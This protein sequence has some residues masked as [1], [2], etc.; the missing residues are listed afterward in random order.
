MK[1]EALHSYWLDFQGTGSCYALCQKRKAIITLN[2]V[3]TLRDTEITG[4]VRMSHCCNRGINMGMTNLALILTKAGSIWR[5]HAHHNYWS[6]E[7]MARQ[8]IDHRQ[9]GLLLPW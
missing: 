2:E 9:W 4:L 6:P 3:K 8:D 7:P 5:T 1:W